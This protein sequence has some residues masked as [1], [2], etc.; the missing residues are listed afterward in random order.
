MYYYK[1]IDDNYLLITLLTLFNKILL[2]FSMYR[3]RIS[4]FYVSSLDRK[5]TPSKVADDIVIFMASLSMAI[6][7]MHSAMTNVTP[8]LTNP[9][10]KIKCQ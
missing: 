1:L 4:I 5:E 10:I 6:K 3:A 2:G 8:I 7:M 9:T